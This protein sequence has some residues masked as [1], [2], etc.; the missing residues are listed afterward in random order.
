MYIEAYEQMINDYNAAIDLANEVPELLEDEELVNAM[1]ELTAGIDTITELM[2]D[3]ANMTDEFLANLE[4]S[5]ELTYVTINRVNSLAELLPILTI[6]GAGADEAE[7]TYWFA[8]SEDE[9]VGVM[10]ILSADQTQN[11]YCAGSMVINEDGTYTIYDEDGYT[12]TMAVE[13]VED[14][15]LL[16]M[17]DGTQVGMFAAAPKDVIDIMLAIEEG[18]ENVNAQ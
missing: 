9:T 2:A 11:V 5:M 10:V 17:Q 8:C 4:T 14:G 3:P 6:A 12:M 18:T 16:T 15:L 13:V 7:N 1:N